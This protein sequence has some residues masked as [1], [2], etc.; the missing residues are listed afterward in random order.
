M[1]SRLILRS[2]TCRNWKPPPAG[3]PPPHRRVQRKVREALLGYALVLPSLVV[4][5]VFVFYPFARNFWLALHRTPPFP[6]LP[7]RYVGLDQVGDA[8]QTA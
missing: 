8:K 7:K 1:A 5:G 3:A 2:T 6:G 4:F